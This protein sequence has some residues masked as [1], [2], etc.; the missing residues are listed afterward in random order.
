[1]ILAQ[2]SDIVLLDEPTTWLDIGHQIELLQLL[3]VLQRQR[4]WTIVMAL[5]DLNQASHYGERVLAMRHG[6][7]VADGMAQD[8]MTSR[9]TEQLFGL[10]TQR[11]ERTVAGRV[12]PYCLPVA[13]HPR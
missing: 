2:Q 12:V 9:L 13:V 1:M 6:R 11:V 7:I 8:I 3:A 4:Q 10:V 5:H